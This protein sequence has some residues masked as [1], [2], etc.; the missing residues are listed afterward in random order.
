MRSY[1]VVFPTF[2]L[3]EADLSYFLST[4]EGIHYLE[5]I[6]NVYLEYLWISEY[7]IIYLSPIGLVIIGS[8]NSSENQD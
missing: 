7:L 4:W 3:I 8:L 6:C 5:Y 2:I 1:I